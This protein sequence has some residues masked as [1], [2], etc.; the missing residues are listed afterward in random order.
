MGLLTG[1]GGGSAPQEPRDDEVVEGQPDDPIQSD[2]CLLGDWLLDVADYGAHSEDYLTS[3]G[4]PI[5]EFAMDGSG[6]LTFGA[7][8]A[9]A[10]N[11][12]LTTTGVLVAGDTRVPITVPSHYGGSGTWSRP[13]AEVDAIDIADWSAQGA[14]AAPDSDVPVPLPD[15]ASDPR[16]FVQCFEDQLILQGAD[17]PFGSSWTRTG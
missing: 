11:I 8:G 17:A 12:D 14:D 6:F 3:S 2:D 9:V 13:Q 15:F 16:V 7:D 5:T 1:C 10:M 4:I